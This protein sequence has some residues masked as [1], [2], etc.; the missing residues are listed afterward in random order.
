LVLGAAGSVDRMRAFAKELVGLQ[1]EVIL[2]GGR[3]A[4]A[5]FTAQ[6]A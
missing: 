4:W 6:R 1:P 5:V 2:S 3:H